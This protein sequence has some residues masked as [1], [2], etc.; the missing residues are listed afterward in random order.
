MRGNFDR[1][2]HSRQA[3]GPV[4]EIT[5]GDIYR[6]VR[7]VRGV[8]EEYEQCS[9]G[10]EE[11][12]DNIEDLLKRLDWVSTPKNLHR[13][14]DVILDVME[15]GLG[16]LTA[17][18]QDL[19]NADHSV[20]RM[21]AETRRL[22]Q[23]IRQPGDSIQVTL[24]QQTIQVRSQIQQVVLRLIAREG[25]ARSWRIQQQVI[26]SGLTQN[27]NSVRNALRKLCGKGLVSDYTW[28]GHKVGWSPAPGGRRR[29]V[30]LTDTGVTWCGEVFGEQPVESEI[31]PMARK[32]NSVGH[33]VGILEARDHLRAQ[34]YPVD[35]A[36]EPIL[37][38]KGERWGRRVEP[39]L[40]VVM[41]KQTW[42]V[43]VQREVAPRHTAKKWSKVLN[44]TRRLALILF[45]DEK[46]DQQMEILEETTNDLPGGVIRLSSLEA[47]ERGAWEW[48]SLVSVDGW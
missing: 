23:M 4:A 11:I 43:E 26:K 39:D 34:G 3:S 21:Q 41:E 10:D 33:A 36:P 45:S 6:V 28:N 42:P 25:L 46:L 44:L 18:I 32:H 29:L 8:K 7:M 38:E 1:D 15:W 9:W 48:T 12:L 20:E 31:K 19:E 2:A 47:M 37:E 14:T 27:E 40:T 13:A 22:R 30:T 35:D 24:P 17:Y 5:P 16:D